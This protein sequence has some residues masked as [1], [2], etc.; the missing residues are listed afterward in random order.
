[1]AMRTM[2][3]AFVVLGLVWPALFSIFDSVVRVLFAA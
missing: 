2:L 3:M 1:M